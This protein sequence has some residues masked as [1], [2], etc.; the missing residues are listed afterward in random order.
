MVQRVRSVCVM[1]FIRITVL[2]AVTVFS[3][4]APL[5]SLPQ[6]KSGVL[7][8][9]D[10]V[11]IA[12]E[13][14]RKGFDSVVIICPG[15]YNSK[16]NRWM[17]KTADMILSEHDVIIF[18]MR[19]HGES[20]GK[21]S[22]SAREH[23]DIEAVA[24]YAKAEGYKHIG[25]LAFSLGAAS[26]I[27]AAAIRD[28][29]DSMVLISCPTSF[30]MV[31][32][33]FW[34]PGMFS[35]LKDNIDCKWE[36]KGARVTN[37]FIPKQKPIDSIAK[38]KNTAILFIHGDKDWVIK[39][40][41]SRKLYDASH[42]RKKLEVIKNGL[43]AE[44][45]IQ[46]HP[47]RTEALILDWFRETLGAKGSEYAKSEEAAAWKE[48]FEASSGKVR[49]IPEG[50]QL[51]GKPGTPPA[52][53]YAEKDDKEGISYLHVE[54]DRASA[55]IVCPAEGVDLRKTPFLRWRWR[56][57]ILPEGADGRLRAKDDQ[58][59]GIYVGTGS[60]L[61]NKSIS[62]R[63]DTETP[64]GSKGNAV[65]GGGTVK[66]KW[67]TLRNK[68]DMKGGQWYAEE[69]DCAEDFKKAWGFCPEK[70]YLSVSCNSQYTGTK[71]AADLDWIEFVKGSD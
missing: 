71:A 28:D 10:N 12:Y 41:H 1:R 20:S 55:S 8:T 29:I 67:Y 43:H 40:S 58:A 23:M 34:E 52:T 3:L 49:Q 56:V 27:N 42:G 62:Y 19:G 31:N 21:F 26:S 37:I 9:R 51:K 68:E 22:W 65:Y 16:E 60:M 14:Y 48:D 47:D 36:G 46:M 18:D 54:A 6:G 63:W 61:N 66:V 45:L 39:D 44:R 35:D 57:T 69:R 2:L 30:R 50:W 59:I 15:F 32:F 7:R 53:F 5:W 38:V 64:K 70:V 17:R 13:H 4:H 11:V 33:H 25:I 24:D